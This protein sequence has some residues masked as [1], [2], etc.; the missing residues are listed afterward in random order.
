MPTL[1]A[2][3]FRTADTG[4]AWGRVD[5]AVA[6]RAATA[7]SA[8]DDDFWE[9][10]E[11]ANGDRLTLNEVTVAA[12][13]SPSKVICIGLNYARHAAESG[14]ALPAAPLVFAKWPTS[15]LSPGADLLLSPGHGF[16]DYEAEVAV[17]IGRAARN[18]A[19][20]AEAIEAIGA[21]TG[22]NDIT[23]RD[24]QMSDGQWTRGKGHDGYGPVGPYLVRS[25]GL[26]L[27][28]IAIEATLNGQTVQSSSTADLI[29]DIPTIVRYVS[30]TCS[31]LP[32]DVIAT[33]TPEGI[34]Y[35]ATPPRPL[36]DGDVFTV[37]IQHAGDLTTRI[38]D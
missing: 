3:R 27:A 35:A 29:F 12:P 6:V 11:R 14:L 10:I 38:I 25:A 18:L 9:A 22:F 34:G 13:V 19:T 31:L 4:F 28:D 17:V 24:E 30:H 20:D 7:A 2:V 5:G 16:V 26:D 15:L 37:R 1:S 36:I 8:P 23:D 32:G 21:I 33:G